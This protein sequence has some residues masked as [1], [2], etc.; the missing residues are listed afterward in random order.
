[1]KLLR[2]GEKNYEKPAILSKERKKKDNSSCIKD[3]KPE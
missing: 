3:F 2:I 1:M